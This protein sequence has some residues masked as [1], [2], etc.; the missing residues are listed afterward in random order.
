MKKG[1]NSHPLQI[2]LS[3][4]FSSGLCLLPVQQMDINKIISNFK[5]FIIE[6]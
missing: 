1:E 5:D 6:S 2:P 3:C 4:K